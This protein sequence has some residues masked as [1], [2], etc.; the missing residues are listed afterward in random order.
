[1]LLW[2]WTTTKSNFLRGCQV[3][4]WLSGLDSLAFWSSIMSRNRNLTTLYAKAINQCC[5]P[6]CKGPLSPIE[7]HHII[8]IHCGGKDKYINMVALCKSCHKKMPKRNCYARCV[9]SQEKLLTWKFRSE[10]LIIG[11]CSDEMSNRE[12]STLLGKSIKA[13]TQYIAC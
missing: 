2:L 11:K 12:Y 9:K 1:M 4:T 6:K 13:R 10:Y 5:N 7:S 3:L 8:P